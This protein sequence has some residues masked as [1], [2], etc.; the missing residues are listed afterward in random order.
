MAKGMSDREL[1]LRRKGQSKVTQ[2]TGTL[3]LAS[4]GAFT[5][6]RA[7]GT[8]KYALKAQK[9]MPKLKRINEDKANKVALGTSTAAGGI[10]G[11][12]AFNF[13]SILDEESKRGA[14]KKD[15]SPLFGEEGI[16]KRYEDEIAKIGDWKTIKQREEEQRKDKSL[17]AV[18]GAAVGIGGGIAA[19]NAMDVDRQ[20][21]RNVGSAARRN[22]ELSDQKLIRQTDAVKH[23]GRAVTRNFKHLAGSSKAG[24]GAVAAGLGVMGAAQG[25][26][27]YNQHKINQRRRA[28]DKVKKDWSPVGRDYDPEKNRA[29]RPEQYA[30]GAAGVLGGASA[31]TGL[32]AVD[33]AGSAKDARARHKKSSDLKSLARKKG[34]TS[35]A[36]AVGAGA[37]GATAA[38]LHQGKI[39]PP[40][41]WE[42]YSKSASTSAFGVLH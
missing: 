13:A 14:V 21:Y 17:S 2:T 22:K 34:R 8:G 39:K 3:G 38:G 41:S 42:S 37:A 1:E 15:D 32:Q 10:G 31:Y 6:G 18:G 28:N 26:K 36:L 7:G 16:A 27:T 23:T 24:Y 33:A 9:A 40:K 19:S 11:A 29:K 4:L 12:G 30:T 35:A 5:I 25:H 20:R